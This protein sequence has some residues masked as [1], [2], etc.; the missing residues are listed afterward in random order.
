MRKTHPGLSDAM[1]VVVDTVSHPVCG[2]VHDDHT[3]IQIYMQRLC[4]ND[5]AVNGAL[6][7]PGVF[8]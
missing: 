8:P 2:A 3:E 6:A 4:F 1:F 5:D 7:A